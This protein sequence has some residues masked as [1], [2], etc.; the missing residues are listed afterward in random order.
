VRGS[1]GYDDYTVALYRP[2]RP[3]KPHTA[4]P[5]K[6]P[7]LGEVAWPD[8]ITAFYDQIKQGSESGKNRRRLFLVSPNYYPT[9]PTISSAGLAEMRCGARIGLNEV[10]CTPTAPISQLRRSPELQ[11]SKQRFQR[12]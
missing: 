3:K 8:K 12:R 1:F 6:N 5:K 9:L 2:K 11:E 4:P 10:T 7:R